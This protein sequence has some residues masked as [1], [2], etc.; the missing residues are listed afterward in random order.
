MRIIFAILGV[1]SIAACS[2]PQSSAST[3]DSRPQLSIANA[4]PNSLLTIDNV[5][6]GDAAQYAPDKKQ[7]ALDHGTHHIVI[8]ASGT[9]LFD[10]L[11][12]LG[13]GTN[14]TIEL[15]H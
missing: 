2:Y 12:Y 4:P 8:T 13:D 14:R 10:N 5:Q 6:L 9:V 3:V 11:V 1:L 15:P 7:I